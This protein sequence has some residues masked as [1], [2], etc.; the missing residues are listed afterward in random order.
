MLVR[1]TSDCFTRQT[2]GFG[3]HVC[4]SLVWSEGALA[5]WASGGRRFRLDGVIE[6]PSRTYG[7]T[8]LNAAVSC[9]DWTALYERTGT[10][11]MLLRRG[12]MVREFHRS[13]Y[14][15]DAFLFPV[16]LFEHRGRTVLAHCPEH[17]GRLEFEDVETAEKLTAG[18][19]QALDFFHSRLAV[20]PG[21]TRLLSA[22]WVWHP[23]D[24]VAF[25][26]I[27]DAFKSPGSLDVLQTASRS[28]NV[29]LAEESSACWLDESQ[30]ILGGGGEPEDP[31][32]AA[33]ADAFGMRL[34]PNSLAVFDLISRQY[35]K[36]VL[37]G[38]APGEMMPVGLHHVLTFSEYP[39]LV[40]LRKGE[41]VAE[42]PELKS[43]SKASSIVLD[44]PVPVLALDVPNARFA[45]A[46]GSGIEIVEFGTSAME[47]LCCGPEPRSD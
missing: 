38:Y 43:G 13:S 26:D 6:E 40:C 41:V 22:G 27:R 14:H 35:T 44:S 32:E 7:Y 5:D 24:V 18:P 3:E 16:C 11:A 31:E 25:F 1:F 36:V 20:S 9:G 8:R 39:R 37:L 29:C 42:F 45:L 23:W 17:Y 33:E 19:R 2:L 47:R 30:L 28:R 4:K 46:Q 12:E 21:G 10:A 34:K 15:A